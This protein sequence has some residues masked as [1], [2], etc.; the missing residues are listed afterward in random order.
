MKIRLP[1]IK[2]S[3]DDSNL[4]DEIRKDFM[5]SCEIYIFKDETE[6]LDELGIYPFSLWIEYGEENQKSIMCDI[7]LH[8]LE[9]FAHTLLKSI[10]MFRRDYSDEIKKSMINGDAI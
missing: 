9:L 2:P 1:L 6:W 5:K 7:R 10:E 4:T 8:D 3:F